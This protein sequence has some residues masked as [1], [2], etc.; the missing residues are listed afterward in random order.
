MERTPEMRKAQRDGKRHQ[1]WVK[2][3]KMGERNMQ[4]GARVQKIGGK[5]PKTRD[6]RNMG[7]NP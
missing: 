3:P 4:T 1:K 5:K 7:K 2:A 6:T